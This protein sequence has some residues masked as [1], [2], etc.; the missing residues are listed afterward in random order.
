MAYIKEASEQSQVLV[1]EGRSIW[2]AGV[3]WQQVSLN[4]FS[5]L[6]AGWAIGRAIK[7]YIT[8][9]ADPK[10]LISFPFRKEL[11]SERAQTE[12]RYPDLACW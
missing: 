5:S 3:H 4:G 2:K 7:N 11:R 1:V 6:P 9:W 12:W 10:P 8:S